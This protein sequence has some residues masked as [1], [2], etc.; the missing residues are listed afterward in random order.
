MA[1]EQQDPTEEERLLTQED[2]QDRQRVQ[3]LSGVTSPIA[4]IEIIN[5]F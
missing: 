5:P 1:Q 3:N 4:V 2:Q